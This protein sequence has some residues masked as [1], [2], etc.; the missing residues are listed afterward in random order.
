MFKTIADVCPRCGRHM[1]SK[2]SGE[3]QI[4]TLV[5]G[6]A[7][8]VEEYFVCPTC[9]DEN[10]G[11]RF[12]RHSEILRGIL[13]PN[14]KYGYDVEAE[15]G[16][17]LYVDNMQLGEVKCLFE[18][19]YGLSAPISQI[20]AIG[21]RFLKHMAVVHYMSAPLLRKQFELGCVYHVDATCEAGRG[22]ELSVREGWTGIMLGSW[23]IATENEDVIKRHLASTVEVFGEPAAFVSD[24][25]NGMMAAIKSV[26]KEKGLKSRQLACHMHFLKAVGKAI[27]E[28]A[29]Q[30]LK[31]L[32]RKQK[33]LVHLNR[34]IKETGETIKDN[35]A[36]MR[37]FVVEWEKSGG[38]LRIDGYMESVAVLRAIAQWVVM[39]NK[40]CAGQGFPFALPQLKLFG[41]CSKALQS[42]LNHAEKKLF[43][44]DTSKYVERLR[45][46]LQSAADDDEL[47]KAAQDLEAMEAI[48]SELRVVLRLEKTDVYKQEND[49]TAPDNTDFIAKLEAEVSCYLDTLHERLKSGTLTDAE[50]T[51]VCVV[52]E[53]FEKYGAYLF[54]HFYV[55]FDASGNT[56]IKLIE[57]SNNVMEHSYRVQKHQLRRRTGAKNLDFIFERQLPAATMMANLKNPIYQKCVLGNKSRA[58]LMDLIALH[59][60]AMDYRD[61]PMFQDDLEEIGGRL[62][63]ADKRIVGNP[64]FTGVI[65]M[66]SDEY[67]QSQILLEA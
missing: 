11:R 28:A 6:R 58:G 65:N 25:G 3:R 53:Y 14:T 4:A 41:R 43:N 59:N 33:V 5:G 38:N 45:Q 44:V 62:P 49:K 18:S 2:R 54:G 47:K 56:V 15:V 13:P 36:A 9:T 12:I 8:I 66:L 17:L 40:D 24:L 27:L 20:H 48:F 29:Y 26:I 52:L 23:K 37:G 39:Y 46:I 21:A 42:L 7:W 10:T 35:A 57:R 31:T 34:F 60:N 19:R 32:F 61:T 50:M 30:T 22:M 63:A 67:C 1:E 51:A 55:A 64:G 16:Y